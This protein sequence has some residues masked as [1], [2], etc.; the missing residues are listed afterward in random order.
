MG[1]VH[2]EGDGSVALV[3]G[4][5]DYGQGHAA[6]FA[7]VLASRLGVPFEK[8]RLV[9]G[10]SDRIVFGAGTGGSRSMMMSAAAIVQVSALVI[11]KGKAL[12]ADAL[13]AAA[14]DLEFSSGNFIVAGTDRKIS[15]MDLARKFPGK[16]DTTH[17]TDVIPSAFPNGCHVCEVEI[18]PDTGKVEVV[19]YS[20]V[21]DFGTVVNPL[22]VEGQVHGGVV[23][24]IGQCLME[25]AQYDAEG[26]LVTGSF[27][28]YALPLAE[29]AAVLE[30]LVRLAGGVEQLARLLRERV[31]AHADDHDIVRGHRVLHFLYYGAVVV[32]DA[33]ARGGVDVGFVEDGA[34]HEVLLAWN[35]T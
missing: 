29:V 24:G 9:Q 6:P 22:L 18:D 26:Q 7:Q 31:H 33:L 15:L 13:E 12:A 5:L 2:F 28:D 16:L 35:G 21:N 17:V 32:R 23:Q 14:A 1:G 19:R 3:T 20:S 25:N 8:V 10:D 11:E 34:R 27:M 4:T 30:V